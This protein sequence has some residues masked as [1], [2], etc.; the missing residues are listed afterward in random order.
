M[1]K[2]NIKVIWLLFCQVVA[3]LT[4]VLLVWQSF[5]RAPAPSYSDTL[6]IVLPSVVGIYGH[7]IPSLTHLND[8]I[9][10]GVIVDEKFILTNYHLIANMDIIE[11]E[12]NNTRHVAELTGV[13]PEI[14]IAILKITA[15]HLPAI[16]FADDSSLRQGDV[17]FAVGNP[18]GLSRS[19][20]MGIVSAIGRNELGINRYENFIQTDA[21][22]NPGSSGGALTNARG[23]LVGVNSALFARYSG[24]VPPQGIGFAVPSGIIRSSLNDFLP[25][26]SPPQNPFG[27]EIRPMSERLHTEILNFTPA[28]TPVMLVSRVWKGT[29]AEKMGILPGD[30]VL[31]I[32][33]DPTQNISETGVLPAT[34]QSMLILRAGERKI[35]E[36]PPLE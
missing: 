21:A 15:A 33:D 10:A 5:W 34:L 13:D 4:A 20:S 12:I 6:A 29:P 19:A 22:I 11:V 23:E 3:V 36:L 18:F 26:L 28:H 1:L 32:N 25:P 30:I 35:L 27:A 17:V 24:G 14:D 7:K 31:N 8:S 2:T 16:A 9:G